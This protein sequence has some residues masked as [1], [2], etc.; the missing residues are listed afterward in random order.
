MRQRRRRV[1]RNLLTFLLVTGAMVLRVMARRD[2]QD[3]GRCLET[4]RFIAQELERAEQRG[5]GVPT[6]LPLPPMAEDQSNATRH[7]YHYSPGN[8]AA[9]KG[10]PGG[11]PLGVVCCDHP[12]PLFTRTDG[13]Y[14]VLSNGQA[15]ELRWMREAEYQQRAAELRLPAQTMVI[16]AP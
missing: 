1:W 9:A 5:L 8:V 7:H 11:Q 4:M 15:F 12:H 2:Q 10:R 16:G 6:N 13:R 14:V 3:V